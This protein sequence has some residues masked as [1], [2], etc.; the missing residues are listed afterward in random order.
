MFECVWASVS[1]CLYSQLKKRKSDDEYSDIV[2]A[3]FI[4]TVLVSK[5][6][7]KCYKYFR[8]LVLLFLICLC[9]WHETYRTSDF[10]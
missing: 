5:K 1:M 2:Y 9:K 7:Y 3:S 10:C 6:A 8:L 4:S